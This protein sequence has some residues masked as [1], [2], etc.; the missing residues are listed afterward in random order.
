MSRFIASREFT[1]RNGS[2]VTLGITRPEAMPNSDASWRC[3]AL[4]TTRS[5]EDREITIVGVDSLDALFLGLDAA[6][7][8]AMA[9]AATEG[10]LFHGGGELALNYEFRTSG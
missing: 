4:L 5:G 9:F 1:D 6:K 2:P 3:S 10:L 7:K 8:L